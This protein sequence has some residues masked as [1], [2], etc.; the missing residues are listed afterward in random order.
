MVYRNHRNAYGFLVAGAILFAM[1]AMVEW[2]DRNPEE[3][4]GGLGFVVLGTIASLI[5]LNGFLGRIEINTDGLHRRTWFGL[6]SHGFAWTSLVSWKVAQVPQSNE[7]SAGT[8]FVEFELTG[9]DGPSWVWI[10]EGQLGIP[11]FFQFADHVRAHVGPK[12][13]FPCQTITIS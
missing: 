11:E 2:G 1:G 4:E 3:P 6:V 12:E 9:T 13:R 5:A 8:W 7:E 10:N